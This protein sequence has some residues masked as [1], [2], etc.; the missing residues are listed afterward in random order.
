VQPGVVD[1]GSDS[2]AVLDILSRPDDDDL[3]DV[4]EL[5]ATIC[6]AQAA[7]ITVAKDGDFHVPITYGIEPFV[8]PSSD[9]F[10][11]HTMGT[12]AVYSIEDARSD[13]RFAEIGWVNG[14]IAKARF[15]AS[16]PIYAPNGAMVGRLC[17]IDP[18][19]KTL[20][21]LQRRSLA[22]LGASITHLIELRLLRETKPAFASPEA[23][24]AAATVVSQLA[25]ELS[26]DLRVPLSSITASVELLEEELVDRTNPVVEALL[27]RTARAAARMGRMLDQSMEYGA[28]GEEPAFTKVDLAQLAEQL[29]LSSATLLEA[30]GARVE[31]AD[32]PVVH[33]DPDDMYSVLQNLLTNSVKFA[34]PDVPPEVHISA[35]HLPD[36]WRISFRDN[37]VGIPEE[38]RV[39]VFSL[40][41]RA[42]NDVEGHG[43]GLATVSRI[44]TA[45]GGQVGAD[46]VVG[47]GAEIWFELP[48]DDPDEAAR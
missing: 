9:T 1:P 44:I 22:T 13:P 46:G 21:T 36:C 25:A 11:Q 19:T 34:R 12:T 26:H 14:T 24:Q 30:A 4:V 31:Q 42:A 7:G 32:L 16:A 17:V 35:R 5:V 38:R 29:V 37:G 10:C 15:Y 2:D 18:E 45:H 8:S 39:D 6:D 27:T 48:D 28:S 33:A 41:S 23:G 47:G 20:T 43:I 3:A 40:F